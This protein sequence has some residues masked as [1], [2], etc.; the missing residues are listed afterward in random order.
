[1]NALPLFEFQEDPK[2]KYAYRAHE[3]V[4]EA[5]QKAYRRQPA[6]GLFIG[7]GIGKSSTVTAR[8]ENGVDARPDA[9]RLRELADDVIVGLSA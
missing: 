7:N 9:L 3:A 1:M 6:C 4:L 2:L 8:W 5:F